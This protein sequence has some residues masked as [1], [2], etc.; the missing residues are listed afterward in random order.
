MATRRRFWLRALLG[1]LGLG[2]AGAGVLALPALGVAA[3][4]SAKMICSCV[5]VAGRSAGAC[6]EQDLP[7]L[8]FVR[9]DVDE[10]AREARASAFG[11]R[12]AR[13]RYREE[14]GCILQ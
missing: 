13:A 10:S 6:H 9:V 3:G 7:D 12:S 1:L 8:G 2:V 14:L 4:Y 5:F 11:L